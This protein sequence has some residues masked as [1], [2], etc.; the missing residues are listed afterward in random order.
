MKTDETIV[1]LVQ[2]ELRL[3]RKCTILTVAHR[4]ETI[5]QADRILV[6]RDGLV[7]EYDH[8]KNLLRK[9]GSEFF[10]L[11]SSLGTA[12]S[13]RLLNLAD[14]SVSNL[15]AVDDDDDQAHV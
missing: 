14:T 6:M 3:K 4:V 15:H 8:P 10:S 7:T 9:Q 13:S 1:R 11:V 12:A 2:D 5:I